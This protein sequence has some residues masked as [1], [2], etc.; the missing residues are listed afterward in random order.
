MAV[1]WEKYGV[2]F[3][4]EDYLVLSEKNV[5]NLVFPLNMIGPKGIKEVLHINQH[6]RWALVVLVWDGR[7]RLATRWFWSPLGD[8]NS[9]GVPTWHVIPDELAEAILNKMMDD[10]SI[11]PEMVATWLPQI[12]KTR[13]EI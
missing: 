3:D 10:K 4:D 13:F 6:N 2:E 7:I 1:N 12:G 8:P 5:K 11:T 9:R